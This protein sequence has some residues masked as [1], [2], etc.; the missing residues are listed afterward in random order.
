MFQF[1]LQINFTN[2]T[3]PQRR[4]RGHV[5]AARSRSAQRRLLLKSDEESSFLT[6]GAGGHPTRKRSRAEP[7]VK[8]EASTWFIICWHLRSMSQP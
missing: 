3:C 1:Q 5:Q 7:Q 4:R 6:S 8:H 2:Q